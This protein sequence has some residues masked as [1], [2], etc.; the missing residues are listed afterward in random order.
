MRKSLLS[1]L[2]KSGAI[3][4]TARVQNMLTVATSARNIYANKLREEIKNESKKYYNE[5]EINELI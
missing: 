2:K 4:S 1:V 3:K 5:V